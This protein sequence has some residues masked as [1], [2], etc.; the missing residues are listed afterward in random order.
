MASGEKKYNFFKEGEYSTWVLHPWWKVTNLKE[1][2]NKHEIRWRI[3]PLFEQYTTLI[4]RERGKRPFKFKEE[5]KKRQSE[6]SI[7]LT[8]WNAGDEELKKEWAKPH[9]YE[10]GAP[11][12]TSWRAITNLYPFLAPLW[13][14]FLPNHC[15]NLNMITREDIQVGIDY[16][17]KLMHVL[18][19]NT[20]LIEVDQPEVL[21]KTL[22]GIKDKVNG[23]HWG[24]NF[25]PKAG[26]SI[27]HA[28]IQI[29]GIPAGTV[30]DADREIKICDSYDEDVMGKLIEA[31]K[32]EKKELVVKD[33]L[34]GVLI[35]TPFA[36]KVS[37]QVNIICEEISNLIYST[38]QQRKYI[39][40]ALYLTLKGLANLKVEGE[41]K[42]LVSAHINNVNII[43]KQT[44]FDAR[45]SNYR[46][47]FEI[48]PRE[49]A[50][51]FS[52]LSGFYVCDKAPEK[53][54]EKLKMELKKIS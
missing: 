1:N 42:K 50:F 44:R 34:P 18:R 13:W 14:I 28:H 9:Y 19:G 4:A 25:G 17:F 12:A 35:Y 22:K 33:D 20:E 37:H 10:K 36:P 8:L 32:K 7:D 51:G 43:V 39:S 2:L 47:N 40:E 21:A 41:N 3:Q 53:T 26:A 29:G 16:A 52:E 6:C 23:V 15:E 30:G 5:E 46:L 11:P 27:D 49:T 38:E 48:I 45:R 54:A 24:M 31:I